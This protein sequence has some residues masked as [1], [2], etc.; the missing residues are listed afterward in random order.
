MAIHYHQTTTAPQAFAGSALGLSFQDQ[1][2][3]G[4]DALALAALSAVF[5]LVIVGLAV[6]SRRRKVVSGREELPGSDARNA[7]QS[8][9]IDE[10][11]AIVRSYLR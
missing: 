6:K 3:N 7:S 10:A 1:F 4:M 5:V 11:V 8:K 2:S 9:S